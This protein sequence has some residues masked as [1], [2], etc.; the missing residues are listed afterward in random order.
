MGRYLKQN[1]F[2]VGLSVALCVVSGVTTVLIAMVLQRVMDVALSGTLEEFVPTVVFSVVYFIFIGIVAFCAMIV[3]TK[4][5]FLTLRAVRKSVFAGIMR[6]DMEQFHNVNTADYLSALNNDIN[7]VEKDYLDPFFEAI[8][9]GVHFVTALVVM[10]YFDAIVT[11]VVI[12]A[13]LLMF[14]VPGLLGGAMQKRQ[15]E[16][17]QKLSEFMQRLKDFFSGFEVIKSYRMGGFIQ[18]EFGRRNSKIFLAQYRLGKLVAAN[19]GLS[20]ILSIMVQTAAILLS[21]YFIIIGRITAGTL[22]GLVQASGFLVGPIASLFQSIPRIKGSKPII[23][24]LNNFADYESTGFSGKTVPV[25]EKGINVSGLKFGYKP[26]ELV[27]K[28]ASIT[29]ERGKKYAI[30]GGSGCGKTTLIKLLTGYYSNFDGEISYDG[31]KLHDL[32][33]N[34][35]SEMSSTIHQNIY[36]FDETIKDN[37]CLHKQY[38]EKEFNRAL[39]LS[40]VDLF[41]NDKGLEAS[42]G[43]NGLNLSGGQRQRI[44]VARALIQEK[45]LLILDEGTSAIDMQTAYDIES[46][47]LAMESLTLITITHSLNPELLQ[48]YDSIVFMESGTIA[49]TGA[50]TQLMQGGGA[51]ADYCNLKN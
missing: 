50:Y 8:M 26:D 6:R 40:G 36:L 51:F 38:S 23:E 33:I 18:D 11:A 5:T 25:F 27:L 28:N 32:D 4:L 2:L 1:K 37:I 35:V 20:L 24:R 43:E 14:I 10:I 17:S 13:S 19:N 16:F 39:E 34:L 47:L 29:F 44:A 7:I 15:A 41:I 48:S 49:E 22:L 21:A 9:Q 31:T 12:G 3:T 45:P 42:V 30:I 46:R